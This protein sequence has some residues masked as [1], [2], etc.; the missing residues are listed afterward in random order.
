MDTNDFLQQT[1]IYTNNLQNSDGTYKNGLDVITEILSTFQ[2]T[3][4]QWNGAWCIYQYAQERLF[5]GSVPGTLYNPDFTVDS[6]ITS[7]APITIGRNLDTEP[8]NE[9][10]IERLLVPYQ[11]AKKTFNFQQPNQLIIQSDLSLPVG[12]VPYATNVVAGIRY[13]DYDLAT[14][15]PKWLQTHGD[16][17]Y[18]E[19]ATDDATNTEIERYIVTPATSSFRGVQFNNIP[20]SANDSFDFSLSFRTFTDIS[21]DYAFTI[22]FE[23]VT[24]NATYYNLTT[25]AAIGSTVNVHYTGPFDVAFWDVGPGDTKDILGS[26]DTSQYTNWTLSDFV[27]T[28]GTLPNIPE[29][30]ILLIEVRGNNNTNLSQPFV[31]TLWN[32]ISITFK[33][34]VNQFANATA[35]VHTQTQPQLTKNND[36]STLSF[37]DSPRNTISGCLL[38]IPLVDFQANIGN[39]YFYRTVAWHRGTISEVRRLGELK[40]FDELFL[41]RKVRLIVEGSWYGIID[42]SFENILQINFLLNKYF[43]FGIATFD[44]MTCIFSSTLYEFWDTGEVDG[45]LDNTYT[46]VYLYK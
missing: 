27:E 44:Y 9:N 37:D 4:F 7:E 34:K 17:S 23:L 22:R 18:L 29:D 24:P 28:G 41:Q 14:Y 13:D 39:L 33:N 46:F 40:T 35:Q 25:V 43:L 8:I 2:A 1:V 16:V 15:F 3:L 31:T 5:G 10:Q 6:A 21:D 26:S 45:D 32:N 30:G 36:D 12:A 42:L 38:R 20:V 19:V 11:F